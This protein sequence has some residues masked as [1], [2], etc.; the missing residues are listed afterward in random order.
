MNK[1]IFFANG[2]DLGIK[3]VCDEKVLGKKLVDNKKDLGNKF[4]SSSIFSVTIY[5]SRLQAALR[6]VRVS[7]P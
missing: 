6:Y 7:S 1:I 2:K 5:M 3:L 4:L